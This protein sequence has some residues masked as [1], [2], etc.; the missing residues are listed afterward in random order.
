[1]N[2]WDKE[3]YERLINVQ[4]IW[5]MVINGKISKKTVCLFLALLIAAGVLLSV[6]FD[7]CG[8]GGGNVAIM[9]LIPEGANLDS[10]SEILKDEEII[11][12]PS[13]FRLRVKAGNEDYIFQMGGHSLTGSM[14]YGEVIRKLTEKPEVE[15]N[16]SVKVTIPEGYELWK[17]A[18]K[19]EDEGFVHRDA[20]IEECEKGSFD[21]AFIDE[22]QRDEN[23]L[24]GYLFPATYDLVPGMSEHEIIDMML[25]A[26]NDR[27]VPI[28]K[29]AQTDRTLDE[30]V[31][32]ASMVEREA[33]NDSERGK[34]ASVFYNRLE[35]DMT[36]SSCATVQYIIEERK[37]VLSNSDIKIK[38]PYNTYIN[39][40][41]PI[42]P[43]ASPGEDSFIA[44]VWP[45]DTDYLYFAAKADGSA[46]VFSRTGDEHMKIVDE[47]QGGN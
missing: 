1:M 39:K 31:I 20:F 5:K 36:L 3:R 14:S 44:A 7:V 9:V 11:R 47:I 15:L 35:A 2:I 13:L 23:R 28:Y 6:V 45:E 16:Q 22:I 43:I 21:Y 29:K 46:N 8:V 18:Q 38:S 41:L 40:G 4:K 24:E 26:F 33:A 17:I 25:K 32:M 37:P 10:I 27:I 19:L 42:G 12:Y 30:L 34:V